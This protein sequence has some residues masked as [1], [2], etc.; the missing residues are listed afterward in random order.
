[1]YDVQFQQRMSELFFVLIRLIRCYAFAL[2]K[3]SS[4]IYF[5]NQELEN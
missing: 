5:Y 2:F 1:M 3:K 4:Q